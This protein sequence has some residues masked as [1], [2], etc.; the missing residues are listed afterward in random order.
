M[1]DGAAAKSTPILSFAPGFSALMCA[2]VCANVA[3]PFQEAQLWLFV[4]PPVRRAGWL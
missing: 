4:H 2:I 3:F 1:E